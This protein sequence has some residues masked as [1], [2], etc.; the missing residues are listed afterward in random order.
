MNDPFTLLPTSLPD[1]L[2]E[3]VDTLA[4]IEKDINRYAAIRLETLHIASENLARLSVVDC[5]LDGLLHRVEAI[6]S[7]DDELPQ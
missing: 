6:L 2:L 7:E 1:S 4:N 5:Q 3:C